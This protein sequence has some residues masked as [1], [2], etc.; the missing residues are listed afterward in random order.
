MHSEAQLSCRYLTKLCS[1]VHCLISDEDGERIVWKHEHEHGSEHGEQD[2]DDENDVASSDRLYTF[3]VAV[4]NEQEEI[5][6]INEGF[7]VCPISIHWVLR[8]DCYFPLA[9]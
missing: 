2:S 7:T 3:T 4:T 1:Q 6:I 9:I 5:A 8:A